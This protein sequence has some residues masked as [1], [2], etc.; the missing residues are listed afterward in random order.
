MF[1]LVKARLIRPVVHLLVAVQLLL[2]APVATAL[3]ANEPSSGMT[4]ECATEMAGKHDDGK[5]PCCPDGVTL[6]SCLVTCTAAAAIAP[7]VQVEKLSTHVDMIVSPPVAAL[8]S[9][10]DP[11]LKPP[12]IV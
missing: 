11:P 2:S 6:G 8:A 3:A 7:T 5:C 10:A 9:I 12:P 1:V 4:A